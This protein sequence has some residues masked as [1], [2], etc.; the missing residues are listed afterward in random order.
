MNTQE[1][2]IEVTVPH[3]TALRETIKVK[4]QPCSSKGADWE[5]KTLCVR[6]NDIHHT[7]LVRQHRVN[8]IDLFFEVLN[9][10]LPLV[11]LGVTSGVTV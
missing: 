7:R 2:A 10:S 3:Y 9:I 8:C 1:G 6:C 11:G 5:K 4:M